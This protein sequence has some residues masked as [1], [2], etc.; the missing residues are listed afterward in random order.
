MATPVSASTLMLRARRA[1]N[2]EGATEFIPDDELLDYINT[3]Y[4]S[5]YD[6][7]RL[8]TWGGQYFRSAWPIVTIQNQSLYALAPNTASVISVARIIAH[9][10]QP[11][12][13]LPYQEEQR[14]VFS[15]SMVIGW[16]PVAGRVFYQLQNAAAIGSAAGGINF[17]PIPSGG[18]SI[19]VNYAPTC[20][21]MTNP[22]STINSINGWEEY[23]VLKAAIKC[24][25]KTGNG[26]A[27][28]MLQP[29]LNEERAR[30]ENAAAEMDLG[31]EGVHETEAYGARNLF[32]LFGGH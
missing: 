3:S 7:V 10:N 4:A 25:G 30:I 22:A 23:I 20:P 17:L 5:W 9:N 8:T 14:G 2:L 19:N 31:N 1:A 6:L 27:I 11:V 28:A 16:T 18:Y 13:I 21:V 12:P 32:T 26:A 15:P 29:Q 24:L